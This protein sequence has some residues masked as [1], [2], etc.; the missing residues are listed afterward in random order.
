MVS[1]SVIIK[2]KVVLPWF[3]FLKWISRCRFA[4]PLKK[5]GWVRIT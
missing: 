4:V 2:G 3:L 1:I 5:G